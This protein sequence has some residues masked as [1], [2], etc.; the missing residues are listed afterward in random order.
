M[1]AP[2]NPHGTQYAAF[3]SP[4]GRLSIAAISRPTGDP[5]RGHARNEDIGRLGLPDQ[6]N[7]CVG[8][9]CVATPLKTVVV[10]K[11]YGSAK[12]MVG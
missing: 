2:G 8:E 9:R 3:L 1:I 6:I 11:L 7:E 4:N 12:A 5:Y 10:S